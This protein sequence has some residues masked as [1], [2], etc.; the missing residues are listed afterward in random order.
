MNAAMR[1]RQ[2]PVILLAAAALGVG[3][4]G[5]VVGLSISPGEFYRAWLCSFLFW[6]GLPLAG[7][8]LTLVHD[9]T[10]GEWM[11]AARP[12]LNAA[13][14]TMPLA[15]LAGIPAFIG[16]D[17]IYGWTHPA[18]GL[19]NLF[20]LNRTDFF[21]RYGAYVVVWNL[22]AAFAV[23]GPRQGLRPIAPRQS[24]ISGLG[25]V[26]L[27]L[28]MSFAAIDWILSLEPKFW[29][30]IFPYTQGASWFNTGMAM[31]VLAVASAGRQLGERRA[32][33][34]DLAQILLAMTMFWAYV[35]FIQY[36]I[37]WEE[38]LRTEIPWYVKR[39]DPALAAGARQLGGA[40]IRPAVPRASVDA[41]EAPSRHRRSD[42]RIDPDQP[43]RRHLAAGHAGVQARDANLARCRRR[44]GARRRHGDDVRLEMAPRAARIVS[45][46]ADTGG[47]SWLSRRRQ[48]AGGRSG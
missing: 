32:H 11:E 43:H 3:L 22:L 14:A 23:L 36:L 5:C 2:P 12:A 26:A 25:L 39:L 38:N 13:I 45:R 35:E 1:E 17:T 4:L 27:A 33:M 18:S 8:T 19:G 24:W 21:L 28:S 40:W 16:L 7:V 46:R 37:I 42:V 15:S 47:G 48:K 30:S 6:L 34:A 44:A 20:Y 29:S 31:V 41:G 10:G 9:L